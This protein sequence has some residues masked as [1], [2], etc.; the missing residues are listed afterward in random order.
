MNQNTTRRKFLR[1]A[2]LTATGVAIASQLGAR[3]QEIRASVIKCAPRQTFALEGSISTVKSGNWSDPGTWG[4]KL[5]V[6]S[7][8]PLIS[9]GHIVTYDLTTASYAGVSVSSGATLQFDSSKSTT[10]QSSGNVVVEGTLQMTPSSASVVQLLQ[11][12]NVDMAKFIGGGMDV[13]PTDIGLWVMGTGVLNLV[14]SAKTSFTRAAGSIAA[15]TT[16]VS[17]NGTPA[18]WQAGD[19]ITIAPTQSP[20]FGDAYLTGFEDRTINSISGSSITLNAATIRV[21]PQINNIWTAEIINLTRNVRIEGTAN[22][23]IHI[24]IRSS[25][26]QTIKNVQIRYAGPRKANGAVTEFVLG[27]YGLHFH[28]CDDGSIGS[29]V[30]GCVIRDCDSHSYVPHVSNGITMKGNVAYNVTEHAFWWDAQ[31][32]THGSVWD[33]NIVA[34]TKFIPGSANSLTV[35]AF[36]LGIGDDN[37]CTNNVVVGNP[38]DY[39]LGGAYLWDEGQI[40]ST[41]IFNH[42]MAHN[43]EGGLVSWQNN[44]QHHVIEDFVMYNCDAGIFAGAYVNS[45]CY[46]NGQLYNAPIIIMAAS[47][48]SNRARYENLVIDAAGLD[49]AVIMN[50]GPLDGPFP[51][52]MRGCTIT[53]HKKAAV[54]NQSPDGAKRLD[55]IQCNISGTVGGTLAAPTSP[56][57]LYLSSDAGPKEVFRVQPVSGQSYQLTHS[58]KTNIAPFAPTIWGNGNG[59]KGEYYK[60]ANLSNL[61]FTRVDPYIVFQEWMILGVHHKIPGV[62][63]SMRWT[64]QIMAQYSEAYTFDL[65]AGGNHRLWI[66]GKLVIDKWQEDYP[67]DYYT[68]P[69]NLVAGQ[70]YDIKLEYANSDTRSG[71]ELSWSSAS[72]PQEYVPMS[73]LFSSPI[74]QPPSNQ[75]PV[76]YA[77][78]DITITL[79]T[80]FVTLD[81]SASKDADGTIVTRAWTKIAG[82]SQFSITSAG[83]ASTTVTGLAAGVYVFRLT[84]T[85]DKGATASD[86]VTVTV[87]AANLKPVAN[88]GADINISLPT[89]STTLNGGSSIDPDGSIV[90]YAWSKVSGPSSFN[91]ADA[92]SAATALSGLVAGTY[93]FRLTIT[94]DKGAMAYDDV[95]VFVSNNTTT[96]TNQAPIANAGA[97]QVIMLPTNSVTLNG[98]ASKDPDGQITKWVWTQVSGPSSAVIVSANQTALVSNLVVGTF[99]FRLTVTDNSG[100]TANDDVTIV[101]N[102]VASPGNQAPTANAG[103]DITV[104]LPWEGITLD[105]SASTDID[106]KIISY[107]WV[108]ISGPAIFSLLTPLAAT[109]V[110]TNM[111]PGT[112]IFR[113]TVMDDKGATGSDTVTVNV[114]DAKV[115]STGILK[116]VASPNPTTTTFKLKISSSNTDPVYIYIYDVSG[117]FMKMYEVPSNSTFTLGGY[118]KPGL[119]TA[120]CVQGSQKALIK[121]LKN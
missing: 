116:V 55:V 59:L 23:R 60:D 93:V 35:T 37:V 32:F 42:N 117:K 45:Y 26:P 28:H 16:A 86:D 84:V 90:K 109:T 76:A 12:I 49:Y 27:R 120:F 104:Q 39:R 68:S 112:Y 92:S 101:V 36:L 70:K 7:D 98:T 77:G 30:E 56:T 47:L 22:G 111:Q 14:G 99:V 81:G 97:D 115:P 51:V 110:L 17:L 46:R 61:V 41:W 102:D 80:N 9:S 67:T 72:L 100:A 8:I 66:D 48:N 29:M 108:K 50:E 78:A 113:L 24:F 71:L 107:K 33:G 89:N 114:L 95:N 38:G 3:K 52:F 25:V 94:D 103:T 87:L 19:S 21:H 5:P 4:G 82:P 15:G 65:Y 44:E 64:G 57:D 58:G 31:E 118:W 106:G 1:D 74:S 75:A 69:I 11:F 13:L 91:F 121:L 79:P 83:S 2:S 73:Q 10:L 54:I 6:S 96:P 40:T 20:S 18:G 105:G 53:G 119:Y 62:N 63:Y 88:A 43:C 85:D 34:L